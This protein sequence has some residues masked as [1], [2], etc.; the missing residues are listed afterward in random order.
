MKLA[1]MGTPLFAVP[2]L[3]TLIN[4]PAHTVE[5]VVTQPD[6]PQGRSRKPI[7]CPVKQAA[8]EHA[9][10]V[11]QP[12]KI[13]TSEEV[14]AALRQH[15]LD[16]VIVV[17]YGQL[18]PPAMLALPRYGFINVHASL[19]PLYRGAAPINRAIIDGRETTGVSIMQLDEG[20]DTG[21]VF[22]T[23]ATPISAID[24][25]ISLAERLA[26]LGA[27][28]LTRAL[29]QIE[30]G[31]KPT[32]QDNHLASYAAL[33]KKEEGLIDWNRDVRQVYNHIRGMQPWPGAF[34][35]MEGRTLKIIKAAWET[36]DGVSEPGLLFKQSKKVMISC[37]GGY[38]I[39]ET[40]QL[41]GK[42]AMD[43]TAFANGLQAGCIKLDQGELL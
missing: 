17:A 4:D 11:L 27:A 34:T 30:K 32:A 33:L 36:A 31:L 18:I 35:H 39:P 2:C 7:S 10:P 21:P 22:M 43:V 14:L 42:K 13:R 25:A 23:A 12:E 40:V 1:F 38:I 28:T 6:R 37:Q 41:E 29:E 19:L 24:T 20:M 3:Q 9:I 16:A 5:L 8:L 26:G 15:S